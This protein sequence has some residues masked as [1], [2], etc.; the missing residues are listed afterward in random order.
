MTRHAGRLRGYY[1]LLQAARLLRFVPGLWR[2]PLIG[3]SFRRSL[4]AIAIHD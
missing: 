1:S 3:A 2:A 4:G